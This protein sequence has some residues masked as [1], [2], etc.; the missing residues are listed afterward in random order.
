MD[1]TLGRTLASPHRRLLTVTANEQLG[2]YRVLRVADPEAP[3]PD[4]GQFAML[5]AAGGWGGGR[6]DVPIWRARSRW[7]A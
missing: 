2:A 6:T 4:P 7:R 3:H 5:A 1:A